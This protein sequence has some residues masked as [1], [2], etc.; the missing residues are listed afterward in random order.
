MVYEKT[1]EELKQELSILRKKEAEI[2]EREKI[3]QEIEN[4]RQKYKKPG[5][6]EKLFGGG[7]IEL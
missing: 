1:L 2:L 3:K 4:I 7:N 6:I 5:M